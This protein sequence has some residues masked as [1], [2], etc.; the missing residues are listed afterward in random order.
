MN[1]LYRCRQYVYTR[2]LP[3]VCLSHPLLM[4]YTAKRPG[5]SLEHLQVPAF[6]RNP[7][8]G[9]AGTCM[10]AGPAKGIQAC[11]A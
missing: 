1:Y 4:V 7:S 11:A 2:Q 3:L 10:H 8:T 5:P 9:V 6:P